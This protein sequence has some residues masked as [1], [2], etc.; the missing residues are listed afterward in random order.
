MSELPESLWAR[1]DCDTRQQDE[2]EY[3]QTGRVSSDNRKSRNIRTSAD[4]LI[5]LY[6]LVQD[7]FR[8]NNYQQANV[9]PANLLLHETL[10]GDK[11]TD[12]CVVR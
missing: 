11:Q 3:P 9:P 2:Q 12:F 8:H 1:G 5:P 4:R 10:H 6:G 7:F